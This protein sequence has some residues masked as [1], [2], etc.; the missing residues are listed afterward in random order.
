MAARPFPDLTRRGRARRLRL[1]ARAALAARNLGECSL[2]FLGDD[3]NTLFQARAADGARFVVRIGVHGPVAHSRG[4]TE[5]EAAWLAALRASGFTVPEPVPDHRGR[6]VTP[7]TMPG[8]EGERLVVVFRWLPGR[9]LEERLTPPHVEAY[10]RLAAQLHGHAAGFQPPGNPPLPRYDRVFP[11][12]EP[13]V[14]FAA[15]PTPLLPPERRALFLRVADRV[16]R[17]IARLEAGGPMRLLHGDFH[18]WNVLVHRGHLAA[19]DFEDLMWGW[20]I[21]DVATAFYYLYHRPDFPEALAGFR[22]GYEQVAPW[23][24][25]EPGELDTFIAGRALVLANTV[26]LMPAFPTGEFDTAAFFERAERRLRTIL[27]GGT[28][29]G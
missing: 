20:P 3:T 11:F 24:E 1:M 23:P 28:F 9:L 25:T 6:L 12:Q 10:G 7:L 14:L 18:V 8:I 19:I 13:E 17:A 16:E 26:T 29:T 21:Q 5:A 27:D 15:G 22:R 4:E 2:R